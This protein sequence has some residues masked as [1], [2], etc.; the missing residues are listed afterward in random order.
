M[1]SKLATHTSPCQGV[2]RGHGAQAALRWTS[3]Q[4]WGKGIWQE[5]RRDQKKGIAKIVVKEMKDRKEKIR[6]I[7]VRRGKI[8]MPWQQKNQGN[9]RV[10]I[11]RNNDLAK[12]PITTHITQ[13]PF[14]DDILQIIHN[15]ATHLDLNLPECS[16]IT[17]ILPSLRPPAAVYITFKGCWGSRISIA[18]G[19]DPALHRGWHAA[20]T[21]HF[22]L[23]SLSQHIVSHSDL[24]HLMMFYY[25]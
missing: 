17:H 7:E 16:H 19:H 25:Y 14:G 2:G 1:T 10:I 6:R 9:N 12:T 3:R 23:P 24:A 20:I 5:E 21:R 15:P 11:L 13:L 22:A 18:P 4:E 8:R